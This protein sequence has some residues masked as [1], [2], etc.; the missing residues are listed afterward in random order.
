M[1]AESAD[2]RAF[3]AFRTYPTRDTPAQQDI[4]ARGQKYLSDAR[5]FRKLGNEGWAMLEQVAFAA[6]SLGQINVADECIAKLSAQFPASP[7]VDRLRGLVL[8]ARGDEVAAE[9][10]YAALLDADPSNLA[11][12]KRQVTLSRGRGNVDEALEELLVIVDTWYTDVEA[13]LE[14]ADLYAECGLYSQSLSALSHTLLLNPQNPFHVLR[15]AET[16]YTTQD[17]PLALKFFLR[18]VEMMDDAAD[19][20]GSPAGL[21]GAATRGWYGVKLCARRLLQ[22]PSSSSSGTAAPSD[23]HLAL[24]DE[25]ATERILAAYSSPAVRS[26]PRVGTKNAKRVDEENVVPAE[27]RGVVLKWLQGK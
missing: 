11:I 9:T 14:L 12:R 16:A 3:Q 5:A 20:S 21:A 18:A 27:V 22:A 24:L 8:E 1:G 26:K 10:L 25:L 17:V 2:I 7:R 19:G 13:W 15:S 6:L 4:L 23:Q